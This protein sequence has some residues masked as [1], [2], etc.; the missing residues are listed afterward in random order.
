[1]SKPRFR[2]WSKWAAKHSKKRMLRAQIE[3]HQKLLR[4]QEE[5]LSS[6]KDIA[7]INLAKL[8]RGQIKEHLQLLDA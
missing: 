3:G 2:N 8:A 4:I 6:G 5:Y 7:H 1:M